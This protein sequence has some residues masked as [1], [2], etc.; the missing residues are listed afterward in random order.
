LGNY[1]VTST[2][3]TLSVTPAPLSVSTDDKARLYGDANPPLTGSISGI[4]NSDNITASYAT[5]ATAASAVGGYP[6]TATLADPG[7]KLGNYTVTNPGGTLTVNK[8]PLSVTAADKTRLYGDANPPFTGTIT[9][10][11]NSDNITATYA[12]TATPAS[13]IGG[14]AITPTLVDPGSKLGNYDVTSTNG[15]LSVTPAPLSVSTDDKAR[16]YGDANPPLTGSISGIKNSDNITASYATTATPASAIGGYAITPTLVDPGSKLGN[17]D[18]T[19]TNGTLSVTPAPLSVSTDD[20]AR[21]YGD[22][23]PPLT[24]S[25][26]GIKNSDNITASYATTA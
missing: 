6:I 5:T 25:I 15:T 20:K 2:N 14:Y 22:A 3:G 26:S 9:G 16:L 4:K 11:K 23:N 17:Y 12:S 10:I 21:L 1:D 18:V 13:A 8:A 24:G 7:S 19:S